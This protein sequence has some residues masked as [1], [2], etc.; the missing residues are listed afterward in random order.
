MKNQKPQKNT[1]IEQDKE[2]MTRDSKETKSKDLE[3]HQHANSEGEEVSTNTTTSHKKSLVNDDQLNTSMRKKKTNFEK[4]LELENHNGVNSA[5]ED[6]ALERKLAKKLKLKKRKLGGDDEIDM[7]LEGIP[8]VFDSFDTGENT[9]MED[10]SRKKNSRKK[11]KK[12]SKNNLDLDA[13]VK[14][15]D[16]SVEE[17]E[18][19][20]ENNDAEPPAMVKQAKYVPPQLRST[21]EEHSQIRK[22][23]RGMQ[24]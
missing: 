3:T 19:E 21:S 14:S 16:V 17:V 10:A 4:Y 15:D 12:S 11:H 2:L 6:L 22:R 13:D 8:S 7:L 9:D 24:N 5:N 20:L 18:T 23:V 1:Q